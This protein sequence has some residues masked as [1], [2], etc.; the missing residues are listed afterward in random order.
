MAQ[1]E[2]ALLTVPP[3]AELE[4]LLPATVRERWPDR[5][6]HPAAWA[7]WTGVVWSRLARGD[8]A[9]AWWDEVAASG[10]SEAMVA[11][12]AAE[13][14][15]VVRELGLHEQ[16]EQFELAGLASARDAID[17]A[18]LR[19]SLTADA[20]G[21][22]DAQ[23]AANRLKTAQDAVAQCPANSPR[24]ARQRLRLSWVEVEV[25]FL[26]GKQ[27]PAD[28][29]PWWNDRAG[30]PAMPADYA[31]GSTFHTA[32]GLLF[33][34]VVREDERLLDAAATLAPPA[35]AWGVH[36]ARADRGITGACQAAQR[37]WAHVVVPPGYESLVAATPTAQ[38]L[39]A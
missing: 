27:P 9:W 5:L 30:G 37:A 1:G 35:L 20:V 19:V 36:L 3:R 22:G 29:L 6:R 14:G 33:A 4:E 34:G 11:W 13:R 31:H 24:T 18:M 8:H 32:K 12:I 25:A 15:R 7:V 17:V 2:T 26:E 38:R 39:A 16:A 10:N 23:Q 28:H 21:F